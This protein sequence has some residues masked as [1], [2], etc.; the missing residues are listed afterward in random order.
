VCLRL[1]LKR[2]P[3]DPPSTVEILNEYARPDP[4]D[5]N[6]RVPIARSEAIHGIKSEPSK[7]DLT[8]PRPSSPLGLPVRGDTLVTQ[9]DQP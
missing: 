5:H 7:G 8:A 2:R 9:S 3:M 4:S 1:D 6:L